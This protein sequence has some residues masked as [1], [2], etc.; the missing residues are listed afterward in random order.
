MQAKYLIPYC[1][2]RDTLKF[3]M[4][5][6]HVLKKWNFDLLTPAPGSGGGG[7]GGGRGSAG[8]VFGTLLL[9]S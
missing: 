7:G 1:C 4:Q 6:D 3:D 9:Q 8:I 5:H 2:N